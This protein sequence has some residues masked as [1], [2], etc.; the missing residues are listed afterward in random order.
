MVSSSATSLSFVLFV[1]AMDGKEKQSQGV[2]LFAGV[3]LI[4]LSILML[5]VCL[6]RLFSVALWHHFAFM[7]VSIAFLGYGASGT[8]LMMVPRINT[9]SLRPTLAWLALAFS[10]ATL[11]AYWGSNIIP[12]DPAR[13]IWDR[14]QWVYLLGYYGVLAIPFFFAGLSLSL[15]YTRK[16][17]AVNR[18]YA[19]DLVGAGLGCVAI[20]SMYAFAGAAGAVLA[21]C[22]TAAFASLAF[23]ANG[24][25]VNLVRGAWMVVLCTLIITKPEFLT[26]NISPYKALNIALRYPDARTL[27]TRWHPAARLDVIESKAVRFAPGLSLEFQGSLPEQLGLCLD[28]GHLNA[29]TRFNGNMDD[30]AFTA[31]LPASLPYALGEPDNVLIMEP[32]GGLDILTA[33]YHGAKNIVTTHGNP[34]VLHVMQTVLKDFSGKLYQTH[35]TPVGEQ[36]RSFLLRTS[37]H[38]DVIQLPL[39]DSLGAISSGLYGLSEDYTLTVE[40]FKAYINALT[41]EGLLAVTRYLL[42]PPRYEIRLVALACA[43][44]E[45]MGIEHPERHIGAIRSWGAFTLVVKRNPFESRDIERIKDFC[46]RL[47]FDLVHYPNMSRAEA[48]QYNRFPGPLYHDMIQKVLNAADRDTFYKAYMFDVRPVTDNRPFFY[49]NFRMDK[50]V[51]LFRAV[52]NKWQFFLEGGYLVHLIF[53]QSLVISL[54]LITLPLKKTGRP[55]S[56]WFLAYFGLIGLGFMLVEIC[57]IQRFILFLARPVYA[58]SVVLFSVLVASGLGSYYSKYRSNRPRCLILVPVLIVAYAFA[59]GRLLMVAMGW[60]LWLRS[61]LAFVAILPLG[62][63]LG[64]FFPMGIRTL[65]LVFERGI[66]WAWAVNGCASVVGSVFAV[67]VALAYGFRSVLCLAALAYSLALVALSQMMRYRPRE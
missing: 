33:R 51:P 56:S 9:L 20:F 3:G 58:F 8:F 23:S 18:L 4:S 43:A 14:Y 19:C 54:V 35:V 26:L 45:A 36:A 15:V 53:L 46:R 66:P 44:L 1:A 39:T 24:W 10:M 48:N 27:E 57:L 6:T 38:F 63:M 59:L 22:L 65:S 62:F 55:A 60:P 11:A 29:V 21:V 34:L 12:F 64:M 47:H 17:D 40:A 16:A 31:F 28:G 30:I 5:Q 13:I 7:V 42:P 61:G 50:V 25:K 67:V 49:H 32:M 37:K 52:G 41:P 2:G